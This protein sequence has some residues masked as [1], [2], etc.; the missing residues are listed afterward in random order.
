M[1]LY[2]EWCLKLNN[3]SDD[4]L[5]DVIEGVAEGLNELSM[6]EWE[7]LEAVANDERWQRIKP[8]IPT[9]LPEEEKFGYFLA[10]FG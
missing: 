1:S 9:Q 10:Q 4:E 7:H 2:E 5:F 6:E 3:M 8:N